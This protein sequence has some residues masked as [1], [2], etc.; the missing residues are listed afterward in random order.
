MIAL[1]EARIGTIPQGSHQR[2]ASTLGRSER[3]ESKNSTELGFA[4]LLH[5]L[6]MT[7]LFSRL[8]MGSISGTCTSHQALV[9][10]NIDYFFRDMSLALESLL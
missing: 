4:A 3:L 2:T 10:T 9:K 5:L 7:R 1:L 6:Q 8:P